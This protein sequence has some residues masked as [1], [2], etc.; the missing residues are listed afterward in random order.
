MLTYE[1]LMEQ[2]KIGGMPFTKTRG[3]LREYLQVLILKEVHK[4]ALGRKLYFTGGTYL[5]LVHNF[6]RFSEDLDFNAQG[7]TKNQFENALAVIEKELKRRG[8]KVKLEFDHWQNMYTSRLIFTG[9]EEEYNILSKHSKKQGIIIKLETYKPKWV[10]KTETRTISGYGELYPCVCTDK[11]ILFADKVDA[12][13]KKHRARHLYDIIFMLSNQYPIDR[14]ILKH[15]NIT[16][17]PLDVI[18]DRIMDFSRDDLKKQAEN[19]RPFLF[20][21]TEADLIANAKNIVPSLLEKYRKNMGTRYL[22]K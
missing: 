4:T 20:D 11:S 3:I 15:L 5:R 2:A 22:I 10:V 12:L 21:E 16:K 18:H 8:L 9:I 13:L 1:S 19:L 7:I 17:D 6:K 14:S